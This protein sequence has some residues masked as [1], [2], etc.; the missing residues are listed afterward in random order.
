[1]TYVQARPIKRQNDG[2]E[3]ILGCETDGWMDGWMMLLRLHLGT[4]I[5]AKREEKKCD[6]LVTLRTR[7]MKWRRTNARDRAQ[8]C[9]S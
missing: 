1:M 2:D 9:I 6:V 8:F 4:S 3:K 7:A 5:A